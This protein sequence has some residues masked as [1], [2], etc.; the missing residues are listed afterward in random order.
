MPVS[1][2]RFQ[3]PP[4]GKPFPGA[5]SPAARR[6]STALPWRWGVQTVQA[7]LQV[8]PSPAAPLHGETALTF[9][10]IIGGR[11]A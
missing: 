2:A 1:M 5:H 11:G 10:G 8:R 7:A 4:T 6:A 9:A 3:N